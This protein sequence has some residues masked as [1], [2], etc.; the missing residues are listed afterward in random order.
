MSWLKIAKKKVFYRVRLRWQHN[1]FEETIET[2]NSIGARNAVKARF[3]G[4]QIRKIVR[5]TEKT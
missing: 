3:P 4:C 2:N 1:D 5:H